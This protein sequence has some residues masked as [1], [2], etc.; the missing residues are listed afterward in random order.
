ME[1]VGIRELKARLSAYVK[2]AREG[3]TIVI[4]DRGAPVA[5]LRPISR[6]RAAAE[7]LV[8]EGQA[9]WQGGKPSGFQKVE[10]RGKPVSETVLEERR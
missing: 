3:E 6:E 8:A 7:G 10:V 5:E 4:T 9:A 1:S 2:K